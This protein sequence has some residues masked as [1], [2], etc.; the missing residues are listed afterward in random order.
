M[1][2]KSWVT[3]TFCICT[4]LYRALRK[5]KIYLI[6]FPNT[7]CISGLGLSSPICS[8][9]G[10]KPSITLTD[11]SQITCLQQSDWFLSALVRE[12]MALSEAPCLEMRKTAKHAIHERDVYNLLWPLTANQCAAKHYGPLQGE[13][14]V[15]T[16]SNSCRVCSNLFRGERT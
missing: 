12:R 2:L 3:F 13:E 9:G 5:A 14:R 15:I 11:G 10:L 8:Y 4:L 7:R 16:S 6:G 1:S